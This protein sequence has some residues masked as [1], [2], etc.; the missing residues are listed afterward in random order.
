MAG[1]QL[2]DDYLSRLARRL[3]ADAVDE[4]ADGLTETWQHHRARGLSPAAA[5]RAAIDEFGTAERTTAAFIVQAPGRRTARLLLAT[6]PPIG[7]CWGA[8]LIAAQVW[9][10]TIPVAA[11]ATLAVVLVA[12]VAALVLAATSRRSYRRTRLC[13]IGTIGLLSLDAA[14]LAGAVLI[15]PAMVWPM[16]VAI[17]ASLARIGLALRS[18]PTTLTH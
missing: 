13:G 16:A 9:T 3:P 7:I 14:M 1:H 11:P 15:A 8:S 17:P 12:V 2:I 18:L 5:A 4:L 10:W 6:G